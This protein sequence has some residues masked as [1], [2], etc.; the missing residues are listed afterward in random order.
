MNAILSVLLGGAKLVVTGGAI[1]VGE[2]AARQTGVADAASGVILE[3]LGVPKRKAAVVEAP[4]PALPAAIDIGESRPAIRESVRRI[5]P[6]CAVGPIAISGVEGEEVK[7]ELG[8]C[9]SCEEQAQSVAEQ[10]DALYLGWAEAWS[11]P[12][13]EG[14]NAKPIKNDKKYVTFWG[15]FDDTQ[16]YKDLAAWQSC[17]SKEK[18]AREK[19]AQAA[20]QEA[21]AHKTEVAR[22]AKSAAAREAARQKKTAEWALR[23][24]KKR[25]E[26]QIAHLRALEAARQKKSE[27]DKIAAQIAELEQAKADAEALAAKVSV[28]AKNREQQVEVARLR[29]EVARTASKPGGLDELFREVMLERLRSPETPAPVPREAPPA[30]TALPWGEIP[31]PADELVFEDADVELGEAPGEMDPDIA[32]ALGIEGAANVEDAIELF[33]MRAA[34]WSDEELGDLAANLKAPL[35]NGCAIGACGVV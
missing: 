25:Y 15:N 24:Q 23:A 28:D 10:V 33:G 6:S 27:K 29:E 22:T 30:E 31:S 26:N 1:A 32:S 18:A 17:Q 7:L 11:L 14:C 12:D 20:A 35:E 5:C 34:G 8:R 16:F 9:A 13:I 21:A 4:L 19:A 3:A 2:A